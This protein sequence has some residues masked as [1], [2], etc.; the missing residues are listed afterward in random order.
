MY[1]FASAQ[2]T[3]GYSIMK[4]FKK[5]LSTYV[6]TSKLMMNVDDSTFRPFYPSAEAADDI[7]GLC[8]DGAISHQQA[9]GQ[10]SG[11]LALHMVDN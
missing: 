2:F 1:T 7:I 5:L 11:E 6:E 8:A 10:R 4:R 9:P 3:V